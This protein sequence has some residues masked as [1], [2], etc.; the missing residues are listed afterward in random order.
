MM[1]G[2]L[3]AHCILSVIL[4]I[5]GGY[6]HGSDVSQTIPS[7]F[8]ESNRQLQKAANDLQME[9]Q[10]FQAAI[11][12][13]H[14]K[15]RPLANKVQYHRDMDAKSKAEHKCL[16]GIFFGDIKGFTSNFLLSDARHYVSQ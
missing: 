3:N 5:T 7:S 16:A 13:L 6:V 15:H 4:A 11:H 1:V 12:D 14:M 8:I 9:V 10:S 2:P